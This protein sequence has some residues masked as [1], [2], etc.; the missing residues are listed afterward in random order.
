MP[1]NFTDVWNQMVANLGHKFSKKPTYGTGTI[2]QLVEE[3]DGTGRVTGAYAN[4]DDDEGQYV[5]LSVTGGIGRGDKLVFIKDENLIEGEWRPH[6][7]VRSR[8]PISSP[9]I[10]RKF[11]PPVISG[12]DS[13]LSPGLGGILSLADTDP[14][15]DPTG[16]L[17]ACA[18]VNYLAISPGEYDAYDRHYTSIAYRYRVLGETD[19]VTG[20]QV[21]YKK[22][23]EVPLQPN[24]INT[25][26]L[27]ASMTNVATT[28]AISIPPYFTGTM[29]YNIACYWK[30]DDEYILG[31]IKQDTPTTFYVLSRGVL[32]ST[33]AAHSSGATL[34][35]ISGRFLIE[36]LR[37]STSSADVTYQLQL[38]FV[39]N[40]NIRGMWSE[41]YSFVTFKIT[42]PP[43]TPTNLTVKITKDGY[44]LAWTKIPNQH[45]KQYRVYRYTSNPA[46]GGGDANYSSGQ[47]I[48]GTTLGRI[49]NV[50]QV[51]WPLNNYSPESSGI[52]AKYFCVVAED[53]SGN[54][55]LATAWT[56]DTTPPDSPSPTNVS[57]EA[58]A[59]GPKIIIA[60]ADIADRDEGWAT[61]VLWQA[62]S[63]AGGSKAVV[64][65]FKDREFTY[66]ADPAGTQYYQVTCEDLIGNNGTT[67][68]NATYWKRDDGT[69]SAPAGLN[70]TALQASFKLTWT[71]PSYSQMKNIDYLIIQRSDNVSSFSTH[72]IDKNTDTHFWSTMDVPTPADVATYSYF[73]IGAYDY[74]GNF[75]G[76]SSFDQDTT[77]PASPSAS[78]VLIISGRGQV[79]V[80]ID[81]SENPHLDDSWAEYVLLRA[82]STGGAGETVVQRFRGRK[83]SYTFNPYES[84]YFQVV[85]ADWVGNRGASVGASW[86]LAK[87]M[88][89]NDPR[90]GAPMNGDFEVADPAAPTL[91]RFWTIEQQSLGSPFISAAGPKQFSSIAYASTGGMLGSSCVEFVVGT[92]VGAVP[93]TIWT[94]HSTVRFPTTAY[95]TYNF[96]AYVYL[97]EAIG[98][99]QSAYFNFAAAYH[100]D[101]TTTTKSNTAAIGGTLTGALTASRWYKITGTVG[102]ASFDAYVDI[103][104]TS[105]NGLGGFTPTAGLTWKIDNLNLVPV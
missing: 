3:S 85:S 28:V 97:P 22:I 18:Y 53:D 36:N 76:Y 87:S 41:A 9:N 17:Q 51:N 98:G 54:L 16:I 99:G 33:A 12:A 34:I 95:V 27:T 100:N 37:A 103:H 26:L 70:V 29:L 4:I 25:A 49:G 40:Y 60:N 81:D 88:Y 11:A 61:Y 72:K 101:P 104:I 84:Y 79:D 89:P 93:A 13:I 32:G 75:S 65:R 5:D 50:N 91:P 23:Q 31:Y 14:A 82:T 78:N 56:T 92:T 19:P 15:L 52:S 67:V 1:V 2:R 24:K 48:P 8:Q 21:D 62:T 6:K 77:A 42:E 38:A 80:E 57:I 73:A 47:S 71:K 58:T 69:P 90:T 64:A 68:D 55:S 105:V 20:Q 35:L 83:T 66:T 46:N 39:D 96:S 30:L 86:V 10:D 43:A 102:P 63:T 7:I 94:L 44:K 59:E 45:V 74:N